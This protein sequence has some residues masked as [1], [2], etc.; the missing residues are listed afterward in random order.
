MGD[1]GVPIAII[2]MVA[3]DYFNP[4][5]YTEKL[6][7]PEGLTPSDPQ[8]RGWFIPLSGMKIPIEPWIPFIAALPALLVY[9]L[10]FM[11]THISEY[12]HSKNSVKHNLEEIAF[13]KHIFFY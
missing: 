7:V 12:V 3:A 8:V 5:T 11:E 2:S 13:V 9:I 6:Q 10:V 1:F 4:A